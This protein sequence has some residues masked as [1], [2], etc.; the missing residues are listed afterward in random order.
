MLRE[1]AE[2]TPLP[3]STAD[4]DELLL[5]FAEMVDAR[6]QWIDDHPPITPLTEDARAIVLEIAARDEAWQ[7]ALG[8]ARDAIGQSRHNATRLRAYHR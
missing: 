8:V 4:A 5:A 3:P 2:L 6:Q 1:L 7:H